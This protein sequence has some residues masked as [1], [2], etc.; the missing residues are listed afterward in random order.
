MREAA[1][2]IAVGRTGVGKTYLTNQEIRRYAKKHNRP[3]VIIDINCES[4]YKPYKTIFL[5]DL[6]RVQRG[7]IYKIQPF[8]ENGKPFD[9]EENV[10]LVANV[11]RAFRN[12]MVVIED[13]NK[14]LTSSRTKQIL[15]SIVTYR[16]KSQDIVLHLQSAS[17]IDPTLWQNSRFLRFHKQRDRSSIYIDRVNHQEMIQLAEILVDKEYEKY[18][19][20]GD[21]QAQRYYVL[22]DFDKDKI[23]FS[24]HTRFREACRIYLGKN[25]ADKQEIESALQS[26][27]KP[28]SSENVLEAY[29]Q[30]R[31]YYL[32]NTQALP[33]AKKQI[34][35]AKKQITVEPPLMEEQAQD[36]AQNDDTQ[37]TLPSKSPAPKKVQKTK[38]RNR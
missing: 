22:L 6:K 34:P 13:F 12:G 25:K 5:K 21:E 24:D 16:H 11:L 32:P 28:S 7:K 30:S 38:P 33:A 9:M 19:M 20:H 1:I 29:Y 31:K 37:D 3:V 15:A 26:Q 2:K 36:E 14:I 23:Y 18:T 27:G 8:H 4:E 10:S 17:K 35:E